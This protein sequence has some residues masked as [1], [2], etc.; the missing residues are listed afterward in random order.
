MED[1]PLFPLDK[2]EKNDI[3]QK[4]YFPRRGGRRPSRKKN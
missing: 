2:K 3:I 1:S 4:M